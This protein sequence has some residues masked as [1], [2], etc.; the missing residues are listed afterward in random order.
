MRNIV[1]SDIFQLD[2]CRQDPY[3]FL[4]FDKKTD[5]TQE[6]T[7]SFQTKAD[8]DTFLSKFPPTLLSM[9]IEGRVLRIDR[10]S[11]R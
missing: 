8:I 3:Y 2:K 4:Q 11:P 6:N 1:I 7:N 5:P 10:Y 9:D